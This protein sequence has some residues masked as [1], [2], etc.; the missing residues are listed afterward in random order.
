MNGNVGCRLCGIIW[1][2]ASPFFSGAVRQRN[3]LHA[4][5]TIFS[6][7]SRQPSSTGLAISPFDLPL[8]PSRLTGIRGF[9][10]GSLWAIGRSPST[11]AGA[12]SASPWVSRVQRNLVSKIRILDR[13]KVRIF[14]NVTPHRQI[15]QPSRQT[16][17]GEGERNKS[18]ASNAQSVKKSAEESARDGTTSQTLQ[19]SQRS[20]KSAATLMANKHLIDRLPNMPHIHRPSKEE[21]LAAATGFWSRLKI[22]FKWFSIRSVRPFNADEIGAFFSWFLLGHVL[23]VILGTTT[24]FSLAIFAVN[25]VFAQG[26]F[27]MHLT[28]IDSSQF[29]R[30]TSSMGWELLNEVL[31]YQSCL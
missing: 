15:H 14:G 19:T 11:S 23:W 17:Y 12:R 3:P 2:A 20:V 6:N 4:N 29:A 22:R 26:K 1:S 21:L 5:S 16:K 13:R 28:F 30:N 18:S 24:F 9:A 8:R 27:H 25:T 7:A 31:W 10:S